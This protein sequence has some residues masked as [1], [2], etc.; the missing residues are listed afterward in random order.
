MTISF[1]FE[2]LRRAKHALRQEFMNHDARLVQL[3]DEPFLAQEYM[4]MLERIL[5]FRKGNRGVII[6]LR[7]DMFDWFFSNMGHNN[8]LRMLTI[9]TPL[10]IEN[11]SEDISAAC[12]AWIINGQSERATSSLL[13]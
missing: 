9:G 12:I 7:K 2:E 1:T 3:I 6:E 11:H 8:K 13:R 5:E 4:E 10:P